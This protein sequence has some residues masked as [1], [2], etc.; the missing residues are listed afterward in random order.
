MPPEPP[1]HRDTEPPSHS[2]SQSQRAQPQP[3][4]VQTHPPHP[5]P[6]IPHHPIPPHPNTHPTPS[7]TIPHLRSASNRIQSHP[8]ASHRTATHH[9]IPW[10]CEWLC[11]WVG[12]CGWW[13]GW[14]GLGECMGGRWVGEWVSGWLGECVSGWAE[15]GPRS[16]CTL[17]RSTIEVPTAHQ[18]GGRRT[19][20]R[21]CGPGLLARAHC[22]KWD[23]QWLA[24]LHSEQTI[25]LRAVHDGGW[26]CGE[27]TMD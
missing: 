1:N 21:R 7:H 26:V 3:S 20:P 16:T 17:A 5:N 24:R 12:G 6:P 10:G 11:R 22:R 9:A 4:P 25:V 13:V 15:S 2:L 8:I 19:S 18:R 27:M 14:V 23:S